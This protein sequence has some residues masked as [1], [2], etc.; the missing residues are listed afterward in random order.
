MKK[1]YYFLMVIMMALV[2]VGFAACGDEDE[3]KSSDIVGTWQL[4]YADGNGSGIILFQFTKDG[5]FN[6]VRIYIEEGECDVFQGTYKVSGNKLILTFISQ[7]ETHPV[8]YTYQVNGDKLMINYLGEVGT[9]TRVNDSV[10]EP[11]L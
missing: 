2:S 5:K 11:Y 10:I 4:N 6:E 8:E 3:P 9:Y 1:C 7:F